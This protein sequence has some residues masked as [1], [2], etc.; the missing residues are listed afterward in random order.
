[1]LDIVSTRSGLPSASF[2]GKLLHSKYDPRREAER[3]LS[4][5]D[6][7][8][9]HICILLEPGLDYLGSLIRKKHGET[10]CISLHCIDQL[11]ELV[12]TDH[13]VYFTSDDETVYTFLSRHISDPEISHC[14]Y[15][16][17]EPSALACREEYSRLRNEVSD[18]FKLRNA[19]LTTTGLFGRLWFS[20]MLRNYLSF[21]RL[22]SPFF[23]DRPVLVCASGPSLEKLLPTLV[24]YRSR[25]SVWALSSSL[26]PLLSAGIIPDLIFHTD[27]GF[28]AQ[29]NFRGLR[30][31][32]LGKGGS[33]AP[34]LASSLTA[35]LHDTDFHTFHVLPILSE[36]AV[37]SFLLFDNSFPSVGLPSHGTVS[38]TAYYYALRY[39]RREVFFAGLDLAFLDIKSHAKGHCFYPVHLGLSNRYLPLHHFYFLNSPI[40]E[41]KVRKFGKDSPFWLQNSA[42]NTYSRWFAGLNS[43]PGFYR[44]EPSPVPTPGFQSLGIDAFR[45]LA[46]TFTARTS[47][48]KKLS[49]YDSPSFEKRRNRL[50]ELARLLRKKVD[51]L[52]QV[53]H[54]EQLREMLQTEPLLYEL[55]G[56]ADMPALLRLWRPSADLVEDAGD[57]SSLLD[58]I[59]TLIETIEEKTVR[60]GTEYVS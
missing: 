47:E 51:T 7:S 29:R 15:I 52:S 16:D 38:G 53:K 36:S 33:A 56:Y 28:W 41:G 13:P 46:D 60:Y 59:T 50:L 6:L 55:A 45:T 25:F 49:S 3:Y 34:I 27:A 20:R 42:M 48:D 19:S 12:K 18:F 11:R 31:Y 17:W 44:I 30:R 32:L 1:M 37:E 35:S 57:R 58:S 40:P 54:T 21:R 9:T 14:T 43:T 10:R 4:Q 24:Q 39:C 26:D 23:E 8:T 2:A 5:I 22:A